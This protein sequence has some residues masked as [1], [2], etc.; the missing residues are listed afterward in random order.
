MSSVSEVG[1]AKNVAHFAALIT[2][3]TSYGATYNPSNN[4]IKLAALNTL[5]TNA[6]TALNNVT[7]SVAANT[8]AINNR[9][10]AFQ[11]IKKLATRMLGALTASGATAQQIAN[12]KTINRKIQGS[13]AK[14]TPAP[15]PTP[16]PTP[17]PNPTPTP[18]SPSTQKT[19][20]TTTTISV[21][22]QSY[23]Q[24]IQH[25]QAY[26]A[27]LQTIPAYNPNEAD[28]KITALNTYLANLNTTNTAAITSH[29]AINNTRIARNKI[30]YTPTTGL[31]D[32][33]ET[34]KD[35]LKSVYGSSAPE[36][37]QV[38]TLRFRLQKL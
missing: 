34:V 8:T 13:R 36:Y 18:T 14:L 23:D 19:A 2:Y 20:S 33:A 17:T 10:V 27:L 37:K 38:N 6:Q 21:S 32:I 3:C 24:L 28:L 29:T 16:S 31:C 26:I 35:Y 5:S 11:N 1:H 7:N 30:L 4:A 25:F 12:A 22:Q 15:A 9:I